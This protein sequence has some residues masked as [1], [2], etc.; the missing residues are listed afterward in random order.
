[1]HFQS[2]IL[3]KLNSENLL[4]IEFSA[5]FTK[6]INALLL[7]NMVNTVGIILIKGKF[8]MCIKNFNVHTSL[9]IYYKYTGMKLLILADFKI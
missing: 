6:K 9:G 3:W 8:E 2:V 7:Y 5:I 1:M 4:G